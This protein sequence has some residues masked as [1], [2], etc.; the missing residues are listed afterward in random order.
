MDPVGFEPTTFC[1][2]SR[3][4]TN[5][6]KDPKIELYFRVLKK[7]MPKTLCMIFLDLPG[8]EPGVSPLLTERGT[9]AP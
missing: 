5:C 1:L 2:Q 9:I 3:R 4:A 6:A 7:G 8:I